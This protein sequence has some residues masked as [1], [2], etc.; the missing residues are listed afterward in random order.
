MKKGIL[1]VVGLVLAVCIGAFVY[2]QQFAASGKIAQ[3]VCVEELALGG[4]TTE[5]AKAKIQEYC[6]TQIETKPAVVL[7][8]GTQKGTITAKEIA[9]TINADEMAAE[10]YAVGREGNFVENLIACYKASSETKP[11]RY[12]VAYDQAKLMT[13]LDAIAKETDKPA[14]DA[15]PEVKDGQVTLVADSAGTTLAR[16]KIKEAV[17]AFGTSYPLVIEAPVEQIEP[18]RKLA[19]IAGIKQ[20]LGTYT[21]YYNA[22]KVGRSHNVAL[23]AS[24]INGTILKPGDTFSF[25][26]VVGERTAARGYQNAPVIVDG[27]FEDGLGGGICQTS[28]TLYNAALLADMKIVERESHFFPATYVP[29]GL[30]ATVSWG[31]IDFKFQNARQSDVYILAQAGGGVITIWILGN[32]DNEPLP[33]IEYESM[34]DAVIQNCVF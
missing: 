34:I 31:E 23:S 3:G 28:T 25:N 30:D 7:Q 21:T 6:K 27:K 24:A 19:E 8:A 15:H 12:H 17:T 29:Y 20:V 14:V 13:I 9:L 2:A 4:M 33:Q 16:E 32:T 5:E 11:I 1:I 22:W 10:A 26:E 18:K